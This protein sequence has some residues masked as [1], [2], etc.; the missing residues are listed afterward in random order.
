MGNYADR[1]FPYLSCKGWIRADPYFQTTAE[2]LASIL[3][4]ENASLP[5]SLTLLLEARSKSLAAILDQ[6][7]RKSKAG[8]TVHEVDSV[9][10]NLREV[11]G[12][13]LHTVKAATEV[14]GASTDSPS[15]EGLLLQLLREIENPTAS[16]LDE[17]SPKLH[18]T[19]FNLPNYPLLRRHLPAS[20]LG[21]TPFLSIS[22][23]RNALLPVEAHAQI[24]TWLSKETD[25]VV[26]GVKT[27]VADLRGG[28]RTLA[29]VRGTVRTS[30]A[31]AGPEGLELK[32]QLEDA[33]EERLE[34]VYK[35]HLAAVVDRVEPCLT[36]LLASLPTSD[37]DLDPARFLFDTP[38][39]FPPPSHYALPS[40]LAHSSDPFDSFYEKVT[41]RVQGRSPLIDKGLGE[42]ESHAKDL[43]KDLEGWLGGVTPHNA[44]VAVRC[45][46]LAVLPFCS[47]SSFCSRGTWW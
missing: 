42:L 11:L 14:F 29:R 44:G 33:I 9:L 40:R 17:E 13:V 31:N 10:E 3:V 36:D 26:S 12:L 45:V 41:K 35:A 5:S 21:F 25:R 1:V 30:L 43:R 23:P 19:L 28:A 37:A 8:K 15:S 6:L 4:L 7:P 18:P 47:R 2:T 32:R 38:L 16:T 34:T 39:A 24:H 20:I 22:S 46:P 27:W